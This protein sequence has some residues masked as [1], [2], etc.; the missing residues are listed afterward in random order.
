MGRRKYVVILVSLM[1]LVLM[2]CQLVGLPSLVR[3][4]TTVDGS[5]NVIEESRAVSGFSSVE[6]ATFGEVIIDFDDEESLR[7]EAEDNLMEYFETEVRTGTLVISTQPFTN[8]RTTK[9]VRFYVTM[10]TLDSLRISG[11][12]DI[13]VPDF[14]TDRFSIKID[15]SGDITI[16]SL[17]ANLFELD[18][19]GSG[20]VDID[21]LNAENI[22][23]NVNGSGYIKIDAGLVE[24]QD[25]N[26]NGSG[27]Y[28]AEDLQSP[29]VDVRIGG[30][31]DVTIWATDT[32]D[33][34]IYGSGDVYYY[35]RP[36]LTS[37]GT[38]SGD[39]ISQGDK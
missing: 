2:G 5:G 25:I 31:G 34:S 17:D 32:L 4:R 28:Q 16:S 3:S 27:K 30:S 35:G 10:K 39:V 11:S 23:V 22:E 20:D 9:P 14:E 33:V 13:Q 6:I 7:I 12:A 21:E 24:E 18:I 8:L 38:G 1:A 26:I 15:G 29:I 19:N 37:T 36:Q